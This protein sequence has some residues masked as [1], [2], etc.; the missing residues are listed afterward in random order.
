MARTNSSFSKEVHLFI[1][2]TN[3]KIT[4]IKRLA[5]YNLFSNIVD[6]TPKWIDGHPHS[7][8]AKWNWKISIGALRNSVLKGK[9]PEGSR[10]KDRGF[11]ELKEMTDEDQDIYIENAVPYIFL[12]E[13]GGYPDP[14][15]ASNPRTIGGFSTQAPEG[16]LRIS[17][18][19][20]NMDVDTATKE[21]R[22]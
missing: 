6:R 7:G 11:R 13:E 15:T 9:D 18:M 14:S 17:A 21:V 5:I 1:N 8:T 19:E 2:K 20:W 16:M 12:L 4:L 3:T 22:I 10:T